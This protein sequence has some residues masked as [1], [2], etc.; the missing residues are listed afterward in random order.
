M[1]IKVL[2]IIDNKFRE[3]YG[4]DTIIKYNFARGV[5]IF[6]CHKANVRRS[7]KLFNPE[8]IIIPNLWETSGYQ[9]AKL[10]K[11]KK[12]KV[13]LYH[14]EGLEY[15]DSYL[16][17]KYPL[18]RLNEVDKIFLWSSLE[19]NYFIKN[20]LSEKIV[21]AGSPKYSSFKRIENKEQK[22]NKLNILIITSNRYLTSKIDS[23]IIKSIMMRSLNDLDAGGVSSSQFMKFEVDYLFLISQI[24]HLL[25]N[26][27]HRVSIKVHPMESEKMYQE[28]F[29][30]SMIHNKPHI[31]N[32]IRSNDIIIN[33]LSSTSVDALK[34]GVPVISIINF[35]DI[36]QSTPRLFEYLPSKLGIKPKNLLDLKDILS[37]NKINNINNM[38][39]KQDLLDVEE[40]APSLDSKKIL[41]E[42]IKKMNC[43]SKPINFFH[44]FEYMLS[45]LNIYFRDRRDSYFRWYS[46]KDTKYMKYFDRL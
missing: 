19:E 43:K 13:I 3:L 4:L 10:A 15:S 5:K 37:N 12:I 42:E 32:A 1:K 33:S 22:S 39:N 20:N 16:N 40:L 35:F 11:I 36:K 34:L 41:F 46:L 24:I 27:G 14:S 25:S 38:I 28:A 7:I 6:L 9:F 8:V 18:E 21:L 29:G 30:N 45:E 2:W 26:D 31:G 44:I 23:N 17:I